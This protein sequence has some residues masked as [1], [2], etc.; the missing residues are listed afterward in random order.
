M[1]PHDDKQNASG[2]RE[3]TSG[4]FQKLMFYH[5]SAFPRSDRRRILAICE[6]ADTYKNPEAGLPARIFFPCGMY[7]NQERGIAPEPRVTEL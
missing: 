5:F 1:Y 2:G 7:A 3:E 6:I 4:K